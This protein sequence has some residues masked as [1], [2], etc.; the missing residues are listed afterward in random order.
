[1]N[2]Y[3]RLFFIFFITFGY[4]QQTS[5]K[6]TE[7][8]EFK[9]K[10]KAKE[11]LV[12]HTNSNNKT[13][14]IRASKKNFMFDIFDENLNREFSKIIESTKK[15]EYMGYAA[16]EDIISF[17]TVE[18]PKKKERIVYCHTFNLK[19]SS[20]DKRKLFETTVE[21]GQPIFSGSNKRQTSVA[22]SPD[23]YYL[24][25]ATDNIKKNSNAHKIHVYNTDNFEL[26]HV[27]NYQ[28]LTNK[29]YE[30]N[31]LAVDNSA[32]VYVLGKLYKDGKSQKKGDSANYQ[33][34]LSKVSD[35]EVKNLEINLE[36]NLH[37][38][39]LS[40]NNDNE[41]M[42]LLGFYSNEIAGRIKGGCNFIV[43][44]QTM[45][46]LRSKNTELPKQV[47]E[48]LYGYRKASR[49]KKK[50]KEL[51]RFDVDYVLSD[52]IGNTYLL[53]EEFYITQVYMANGM[54]GGA[55]QTVFHYDDILIMKYNE[56]GDLDWARSIFKRSTAPSY[57]AFIKNDE[58]HVLLNSGK[59]LLEKE[60]GR[61]KVSK[62]WFES[63][64]LYDITYNRE[65]NVSYNKIQDNKGKT[66]YLPYYG[67]YENNKF[68]MMSSGRKK[69]QF[70]K[71]E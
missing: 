41:N 57:N 69:R 62:G 26:E 35:A 2:L 8:S 14:I 19:S 15:E 20:H 63:S 22:I 55:W 45:S 37:I 65:G 28:N 27:T 44:S 58:L 46:V 17:I 53:A 16:Y 23:G 32:V 40:I 10:E 38:Q 61:T 30:P 36:Q 33:F 67:T 47:Y 12:I 66:H 21:K 59:N 1:M 4:S 34:L 42:Q 13:A 49:K 68:V 70:M 60:D 31:D 29:Y 56:L 43:D 71:L 6:I 9:D 25:I 7:S 54:N 11:V 64:S 5:L 52:N 39:S 18:S 51:K 50:G 24:A 3:Y 48:D